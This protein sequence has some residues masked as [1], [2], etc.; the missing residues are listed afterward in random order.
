M[1]FGNKPGKLNIPMYA[2][3]VLLVLTLLS[4]HVTSGLY[5]RYVS[6]GSAGDEA[7]VAT[8]HVTASGTYTHSVTA[9]EGLAPSQSRTA[10]I[11]V[12][13]DSET[14]IRYSIAVENTTGNIVPLTFA[15][16]GAEV[17]AQ[18]WEMDAGETATY[19][20]VVSWPYTDNALDYMGMVDL[21]AITLTAEQID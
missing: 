13:N 2:A 4:L 17:S 7:R 20:L 6:R 8:F 16:A 12:V 19:D 3:G 9:P 15:L 10:K 21:I 14:D 5:A 11:T 18:S 1:A